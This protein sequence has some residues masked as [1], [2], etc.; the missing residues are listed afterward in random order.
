MTKKPVKKKKAESK[1]TRI[2]LK[3]ANVSPDPNQYKPYNPH[4]EPV[5]TYVEIDVPYEEGGRVLV[6]AVKQ[7][8]DIL[9]PDGMAWICKNLSASLRRAWT[10]QPKR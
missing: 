6:K 5:N 8:M 10:T 9:T 7:E 4:F 2:V 1:T 3:W